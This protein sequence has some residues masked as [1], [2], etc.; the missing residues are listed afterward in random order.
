MESESRFIKI[1]LI[2]NLYF[3]SENVGTKKENKDTVRSEKQALKPQEEK[4]GLVSALETGST[5]NSGLGS[6]VL[7]KPGKSIN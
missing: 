3:F 4:G 2:I 7:T 1:A 5:I 6:E